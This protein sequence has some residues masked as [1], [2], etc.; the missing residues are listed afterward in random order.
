MDATNAK[1]LAGRVAIVTG[2]G[3]GIGRAICLTLAG[4]GVTPVIVD[5]D[6]GRAQEV[7]A[8]TAALGREALVYQ[9]DVRGYARAREVVADVLARVGR[10]DVL[11]NNAGITQPKDFLSLTEEDWDLTLD[12]HL[13]G[14]FNWSQ[15]ALP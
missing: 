10:V 7:A 4:R 3:Q 9:A 15:A 2:G 12:I 6:E 11:V 14:A 1:P 8:E 13:K 5:L